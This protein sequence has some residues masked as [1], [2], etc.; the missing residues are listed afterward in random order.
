MSNLPDVPFNS[1]PASI[2]SLTTPAEE[3]SPYTYTMN[4]IDVSVYVTNGIE[5][6]M[7]LRHFELKAHQKPNRRAR[8]ESRV[9]SYIAAYGT[10]SKD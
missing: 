8:D 5:L 1:L 10:K 7:S 2:E 4:G 6:P 9:G 3:A